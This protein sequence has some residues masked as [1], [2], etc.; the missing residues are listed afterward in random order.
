MEIRIARLPHRPGA[1]VPVGEPGSRST[2]NCLVRTPK[3]R[4]STGGIPAAPRAPAG[5]RALARP[6]RG[7][8]PGG[9][10]PRLRPRHRGR[11]R[12]RAWTPSPRPRLIRGCL[13]RAHDHCDGRGPAGRGQRC[14]PWEA[15]TTGRSAATLSQAV[16]TE[17]RPP[18][19]VRA[20]PAASRAAPLRGRPRRVVG[21]LR[22]RRAA[23]GLRDLRG[24][25][26]PGPLPG[27][28]DPPRRP[29]AR[30]APEPSW[31]P[32][33]RTHR[34]ELDAPTLVIVADP[35]DDAYRRLRSLGFVRT[36]TQVGAQ[37]DPP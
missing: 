31:P 19:R 24:R 18:H 25:P 4:R 22:G 27:R 26:G 14:D 15:T 10:A 29:P 28:R 23:V 2:T 35:D 6:L 16:S 37:L 34:G 9:A 7:R 30:A 1:G 3:T 11:R 17:G 21:R 8:A 20:P 33:R 36:E 12:G 5:G 32:R 13:G